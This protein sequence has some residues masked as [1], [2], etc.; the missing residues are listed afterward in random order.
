MHRYLLVLVVASAVAGCAQRPDPPAARV[1]RRLADI[2]LPRD[3]RIVAARVVA[4]ATLASLLRGSRVAEAEAA[5]MVAHAASVFDLRKIRAAQP[6][7]LEQARDGMVRR[8]EYEIDSDRF[9]RLTRAAPP[10]A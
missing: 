1:A 8:F 2:P 5:E 3:S 4:G 7:R 6:Y 9:L 10:G